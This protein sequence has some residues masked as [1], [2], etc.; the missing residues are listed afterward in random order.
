MSHGTAGIKRKRV[1]DVSSVDSGLLASLTAAYARPQPAAPPVAATFALPVEEDAGEELGSAVVPPVLGG[2][3]HRPLLASSRSPL[4]AAAHEVQARLT[5]ASS[6]SSA[7]APP[8]PPAPLPVIPSPA[9]GGRGTHPGIPS[10]LLG[11]MF[12]SA[13]LGTVAGK[14]TKP[15]ILDGAAGGHASV[16]G[17]GTLVTTASVQ[18]AHRRIAGAAASVVPSHA[19]GIGRKLSGRAA[20]ALGSVLTPSAAV[21]S[22]VSATLRSVRESAGAIA[23]TM[24]DEDEKEAE[25][26]AIA[27]PR[28][29]RA[30]RASGN[31]PVG[32]CAALAATAAKAQRRD[33]GGGRGSDGDGADRPALLPVPLVQR[34]HDAWRAYALE[35]T[36]AA[37]KGVSGGVAGAGDGDGDT[38]GLGTRPLRPFPD[39]LPAAWVGDGQQDVTAAAAG[40]GGRPP[41]PSKNVK[42]DKAAAVMAAR[43]AIGSLDTD[44]ASGSTG[45]GK[46]RLKVARLPTAGAGAAASSTGMGMGALL[47]LPPPAALP[48]LLSPAF[49]R[50]LSWHYAHVAVTRCVDASLVGVAGYVIGRGRE[51]ITLQVPVAATASRKT[52]TTAGPAPHAWRAVRVPLV[53]QPLASSSADGPC[54]WLRVAWPTTAASR[55]VAADAAAAAPPAS[56]VHVDVAGDLLLLPG[57]DHLPRTAA[58]ILAATLRAAS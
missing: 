24:R 23:A 20:A 26:E 7:A 6:S 33:G 31:A 35:L 46:R 16:A 39:M 54:T 8:P 2:A 50:R 34:L 3:L 14:L 58:A 41:V 5:Q 44:A 57:G 10:A 11:V 12:G 28:A 4:V 36:A 47:Q 56:S 30:R 9:A 29:K 43:V 45:G 37:Y 32:R 51:A 13:P 42:R 1:Q 18:A 52:T 22:Q 15:L 38:S 55:F 25:A 49:L 53:S 21:A 40:A 19:R 17:G 27:P 48:S